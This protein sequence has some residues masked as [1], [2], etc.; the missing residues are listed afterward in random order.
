MG[1]VQEASRAAA[2]DEIEFQRAKGFL[3]REYGDVLAKEPLRNLF[4]NEEDRLRQAR[5]RRPY[6]EL[7]KSIGETL[8][9]DFN[10]P[11]PAAVASSTTPQPGTAAARQAAKAA[12]PAVPRTAAARLQEAASSKAKTPQEIIAG[13]QAARGKDRLSTPTRR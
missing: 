5:D 9:K 12:A 6:G 4:F 1:L 2:K 10:L 7:Y 13:M 8:R 3:S 11:K